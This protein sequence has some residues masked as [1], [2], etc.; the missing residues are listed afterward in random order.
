MKYVIGSARFL[1]CNLVCFVY[2]YCTTKLVMMTNFE[3]TFL[4]EQSQVCEITEV[5][6][7]AITALDCALTLFVDHSEFHVRAQTNT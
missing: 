6:P 2:R 7:R 3:I 5:Y 4:P 1:R